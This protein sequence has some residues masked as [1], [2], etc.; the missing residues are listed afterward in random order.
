MRYDLRVNL[1]FLLLLSGC[2]T[3][4]TQKAQNE[5]KIN[6]FSNQNWTISSKISFSNSEEKGFAT[7]KWRQRKDNH[8]IDLKFPLNKNIF[9]SGNNKISKIS[10]NGQNHI[11][12]TEDAANELVGLSLPFSNLQWWIKGI[13]V[14]NKPTTGLLVDENKLTKEFSQDG[15]I[16]QLDDYKNINDQLLPMKIAMRGQKNWL[17]LKILSWEF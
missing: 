12:E 14:P 9:I 10:Y 8:Y 4:N 16:I 1:I 15:W 11:L 17:I 5:Q 13:S 7:L 6:I 3:Q 2:L